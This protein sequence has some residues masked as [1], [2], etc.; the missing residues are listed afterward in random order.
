MST[1]QQG[2]LQPFPDPPLLSSEDLDFVA[3]ALLALCES[4]QRA[5]VYTDALFEYKLRRARAREPVI[6][7]KLAAIDPDPLGFCELATIVAHARLTRRQQECLTLRLDGFT[8]SDIGMICGGTRQTARTCFIAV[9]AKLRRSW[10]TYP[11]SGLADVYLSE[12]RRG[13]P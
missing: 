10:R 8:F 2:T 13:L 9:I 6:A 1:Y 12:T 7:R 5:P 4:D 11:Y 3:D